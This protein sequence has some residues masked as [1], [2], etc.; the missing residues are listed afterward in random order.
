MAQS[1]KI[2]FF[3]QKPILQR[4]LIDGIRGAQNDFYCKKQRDSP[5]K[6]LASAYLKKPKR[7]QNDQLTV[8]CH[9]IWISQQAR[10]EPI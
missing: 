6:H 2:L 4:L 9:L 1:P 10:G 8:L 3:H 5:K 7:K